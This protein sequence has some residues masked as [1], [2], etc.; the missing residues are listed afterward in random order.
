ML[1]TVEALG[2]RPMLSECGLLF[3]VNAG[4]SVSNQGRTEQPSLFRVKQ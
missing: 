2:V 1:Y 4:Q 3:Q